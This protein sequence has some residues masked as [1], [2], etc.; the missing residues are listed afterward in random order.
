LYQKASSG[1]HLKPN[2][3]K[4]LLPLLTC[5]LP[6]LAIGQIDTEFWFAAPDVTQGTGSE[7]RRDSTVY[8][9][10]STLNEPAEVRINQPANPAFNPIV[11][12]L[13]A[14]A[15]Q[16]VNLGNFLSLI[17]TK[18]ANS[19]VNT[20]LLIKADAPITAYY[21]IRSASNREIFSL[22]GRNALGTK[23]YTPYENSFGN[24]EFFNTSPYLPPPRAGFAIVAS[25]DSTTVL[26]TPPIDLLG[27]AANT[28]FEVLLMRGQTYCVEAIDAAV[29]NKP[30]GTKIESDK[31]I[32][33]TLK[34]DMIDYDLSSTSGAD[35][36]ADQMFDY[37]WAGT[38]HIA[39]RGNLNANK[40]RVTV[41]ATVDGTSITVNGVAVQGSFNEGEQHVFSFDGPSAFIESDE[42][43]YVFQTTGQSDQLCGA[44]LPPIDC[45]G[46]T[47]IGFVRPAVGPFFSLHITIRAGAEGNFTLNGDPSLIPASAFSPIPGSDGAFLFA[48]IQYSTSQIPLGSANLINNSGDELFHLGVLTASP[49]NSANFG[50]FSSFSY[51]NIGDAREVCLNDS[52]V[53]DAGPGKT[54]YLWSTGETTQTITVTA[55]GTYYVDAFSG[56]QCTASDTVVVTYYEPPITLGANDTICAGT[57]KVFDIP[58]NYL[59]AWNDGSNEQSLE[60]SEEGWVWLEVTDFQGC[61][62]RDSTFVSVRERPETP[63]ISGAST[64]CEGESLS[65]SLNETNDASYR[66]ILP[67][68]SISFGQSIEIENL[69]QQNAGIYAGFVVVEGCESFNDSTEVQIFTAPVVSLPEDDIRCDGE[70]V[71]IEPTVSGEAIAFVWQDGTSGPVYLAT[72]SGSYHLEVSNSNGCTGSDTIALQFNPLPQNPLLQGATEGCEGATLV[73]DTQAET[74]VSYTWTGP[75]GEVW[76]DLN[77]LQLENVVPAIN[78][79]YSVVAALGDC[80]SESTPF[81]I[82]INENPELTIPADT[83]I[84]EGDEILLSVSG[85]FSSYQW[86][87]GPVEPVVV[88][89][90]GLYELQVSNEAGCVD[91]AS[92]SITESAPQASFASSAQGTV[93]PETPVAFTN[94]SIAGASPITGYQWN[95]GDGSI[96]SDLNPVHHYLSVGTFTVTLVVSDASG[97]SSSSAAQVVVSYGFKIP[98]GFSPNGD[99]VNDFLHI[100]G[101]EEYPGSSLQIFNRYGA[102]VF[103]AMNYTNNW[104]GAKVPDGT[105]FYVLKLANGQDFAGPLTIAR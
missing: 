105:Y 104:Q 75:N 78:G 10:V 23:F 15:T 92:I 81:D 12:S 99:G 24:N 96:G 90:A 61:T 102:V 21:E 83:T 56:T 22:K 66:F 17:E 67:D 2:I 46:S 93:A 64:Y 82:Q 39:V 76:A 97:C 4:K 85:D 100:R 18:P 60:V 65:L 50:Y 38:R 69:T 42:K 7:A 86:S 3:M 41:L 71:I 51:L 84:C 101:L 54:G 16:S 29:E 28:T 98:E 49:G 48:K 43:V 34:D 70:E 94:A 40:D 44:L 32:A 74:G 59:F 79:A 80:I 58:G 62:L 13:P 73:I 35:I 53:L 57:S 25:Q 103:E 45:T 30:I 95:F 55:A 11:L 8:I 19:V 87:H 63:A 91:N 31:P 77:V 52:E 20:G 72:A 68:G 89:G 33:V 1:I 14:N 6:L 36:A 37:E 5:L 27:H 47:Q 9:V 88:L 26:I